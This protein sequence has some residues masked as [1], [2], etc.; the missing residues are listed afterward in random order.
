M[1]T[2]YKSGC[3]LLLSLFIS[4]MLTACISMNSREADRSETIIQAERDARTPAE[5]MELAKHFEESAKELQSKANEQ[6]NY[7][8][9]IRASIIFMIGC[10]MMW[11]HILRH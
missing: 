1:T 10:H 5:H 9:V 2:N 11:R 7:Y 4:G 3:Y 8:S 6:K